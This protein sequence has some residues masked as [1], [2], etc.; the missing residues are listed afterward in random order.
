MPEIVTLDV[1]DRPAAG[2][3]RTFGR[4]GRLDAA[5]VPGLRALIPL[6]TARFVTRLL[7]APTLRRAGILAVWDDDAAWERAVGR[8]AEGAREHWHVRGEVVRTAFTE[9]WRGWDPQPSDAAPL[10]DDEPALILI[11]GDLKPRY[12]PAFAQAAPKTVAHAFA[13]PG[14]LGGLTITS[15]PLNTTSC[16]AWRTYAHARDYA[17]TKGPHSTAMR[18]DRANGHH[19]TEWFSRIRPLSESGTLDGRAPF[20]GLLGRVPA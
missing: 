15:A 7:P 9:P 8:F 19:R 10:A 12:V 20:A 18:E 4:A 11:S 13:H 14:Y 5:A 17:Y 3:L 2:A 6:G 1:I 16:S